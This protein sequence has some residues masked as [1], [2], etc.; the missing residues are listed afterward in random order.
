MIHAVV[1]TIHIASGATGLLIGPLTMRAPKRR[2][3]HTRLGTAY[4]VASAGL[5][6]TAVGLVL[7]HP[8][9]WPLAPI[10]VATEAAA[11]G[12]LLVRRAARPGWLPVHISLMC[13][14]YVSFVTAFLVVNFPGSAIPWIVPT[15]VGTPLIAW[16]A[17]T[18]TGPR[19]PAT[20]DA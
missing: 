16:S 11:L 17:A 7:L 15:I 6:T 8:V 10:A 14:S 4:Q 3:L 20:V 5:C 18:H 12:G 13:G 19:R 2:G 1:L 9:A